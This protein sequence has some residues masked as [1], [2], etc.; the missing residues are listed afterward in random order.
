[1]AY[2]PHTPADRAHMMAALGID[3]VEALFADIPPDVHAPG[4]ELGPAASELEIVRDIAEL[5]GRNRVGLASFLGA[6]TERVRKAYP[7]GPHGVWFP[8][9]RLFFVARKPAQARAKP[10]GIRIPS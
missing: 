9:P 2:G 1:M 10:L 8:F 6:Y 3:S 7:A 5:A 4:L